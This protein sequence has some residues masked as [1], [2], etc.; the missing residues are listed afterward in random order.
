MRVPRLRVI[1]AVQSVDLVFG[2]R[3]LA[4]WVAGL[5]DLLGRVR[6][7]DARHDG[8]PVLGAANVTRVTQSVHSGHCRGISRQRTAVGLA[9]APVRWSLCHGSRAPVTAVISDWM[10]TRYMSWR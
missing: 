7:A 5:D 1:F 8:T 3:D 2:D 4:A 10:T 9:S 6:R